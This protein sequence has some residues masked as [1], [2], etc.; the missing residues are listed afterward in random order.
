MKF[1]AV[2]SILILSTILFESE[3]QFSF[4]GGSNFQFNNRL[5]S[6][7]GQVNEQN[8]GTGSTMDQLGSNSAGQ[9]QGFGSGMNVFGS[10]SGVNFPSNINGGGFGS[11]TEFTFPTNNQNTGFQGI[12]PTTNPSNINSFNSSP[13]SQGFG[14]NGSSF[15]PVN[16]K[17]NNNSGKIVQL[18]S[19]SRNYE[20]L[21]NNLKNPTWGSAMTNF[22]RLCSPNYQDG[23]SKTWKSHPNARVLSNSLGAITGPFQNSK[24]GINLLFVQFGQFLDHDL[25]VVVGGEP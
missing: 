20:G 21:D 22:K 7:F 15:Q 11:N 19:I 12:F 3:S 1:L 6:N 17:N 4:N 8:F 24:A 18:K 10:N 5:T 25:G 16:T 14:S 2:G 9:S 23:V 13:I